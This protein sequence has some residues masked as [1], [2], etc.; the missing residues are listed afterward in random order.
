MHDLVEAR[1]GHG[2]EIRLLDLP[3][4]RCTYLRHVMER[5]GIVK[6]NMIAVERMEEL[7]CLSRNRRG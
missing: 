5:F 3:G 4:A 1:G 7:Y 6:D 2:N